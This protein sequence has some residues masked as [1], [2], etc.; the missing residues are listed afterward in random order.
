MEEEAVKLASKPR[1]ANENN[2]I[3]FYIHKE[4]QKKF[5]NDYDILEKMCSFVP[6]VAVPRPKKAQALG[7][8]TGG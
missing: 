5:F 4:G 2:E 3:L 6:Q 1:H 8:N 7:T